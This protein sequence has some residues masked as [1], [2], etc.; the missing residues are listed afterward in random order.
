MH[1]D[2]QDDHD[3]DVSPDEAK[4]I[5][6][7]LTPEVVEGPLPADV[8]TVAGIDVSIR[9]DTAQAAISVLALPE[10]ERVDEAVHRCD[11][12]FPY[13]PGLLSFRET[14]PVLPAL[15]QLSVTPDVLMT[16]SH[17]LAHPRRFGFAC[18]LGVLLDHPTFGV[19]KSILVGEPEGTLGTEKGS[20]VPLEDKGETVG[21]VLRTRT[22]VNPVYVSVGHRI[23]L[24]DAVSVT[25]A[26][27]P[28]YKIPEPTRQAHKLSRKQK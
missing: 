24:D 6:E 20:R 16:D 17:G 3:W 21:A 14:P 10:M 9:D 19:A 12:P 23:T 15:E 18:H 26:C 11:V 28:R 27:S 5:Q 2:L 22:D 13:V 4:K 7:R 25:L 1:V 8:E